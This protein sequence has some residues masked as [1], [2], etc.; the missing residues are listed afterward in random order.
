MLVVSTVICLITIMLQACCPWLGSEDSD[1]A[2]I[3]RNKVDNPRS[4]VRNPFTSN[5]NHSLSS[6]SKIQSNM[7]EIYK[8]F[9]AGY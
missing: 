6:I 4:A 3:N 9:N 8:F 5:R 7:R 2:T 1:I